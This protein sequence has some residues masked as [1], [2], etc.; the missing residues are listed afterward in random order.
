MSNR[1]PLSVEYLQSLKEILNQQ[2]V[3]SAD[4]IYQALRAKGYEYAGWG[5]VIKTIEY[6]AYD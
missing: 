2:G 6:S 1:K 4:E 5:Y 3:T